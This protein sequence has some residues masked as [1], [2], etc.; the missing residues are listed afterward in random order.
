[1]QELIDEFIPVAAEY[2][3]WPRALSTVPVY[4]D[5]LMRSGLGDRPSFLRA[6]QPLL[7][8]YS[9]LIGIFAVAPNGTPLASPITNPRKDDDTALRR[10]LATA[11]DHYQSLSKTERLITGA[12][13]PLAGDR[14]RWLTLLG[15]SSVPEDTL[16]L[17][18]YTRDLAGKPAKNNPGVYE[19]EWT[20]ENWNSD[21][22]WLDGMQDILPGDPRVGQIYPVP[23][24]V[25]LRLA[26]HHLLDN[27]LGKTLPFER[28]DVEVAEMTFQILEASPGELVLGLKGRTRAVE[29]GVW[30]QCEVCP[31]E[32]AE[33]GFETNLTGWITFDRTARKFSRFDLVALGTRWGSTASNRRYDREY[34]PPTDN[35]APS[36]IGVAFRLYQGPVERSVPPASV[37]KIGAAYFDRTPGDG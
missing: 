26:Q 33:R 2:Q 1:M 17:Q 22:V 27:V 28:K 21:F 24:W 14:W 9:T 4:R 29:R 20:R 32:A 18:S 16:V 30:P 3:T 10:M 12:L 13:P 31:V 8:G 35:R 6:W 34:D 7:E 23:D 36:P 37:W 25:T 5:F 15:K 11:L 19:A